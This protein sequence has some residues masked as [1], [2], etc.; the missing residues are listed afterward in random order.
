MST[1][2]RAVELGGGREF[3]H[4]LGSSPGHM[5]ESRS[6]RPVMP[7]ANQ[8]F[9]RVYRGPPGTFSFFGFLAPINNKLC[10]LSIPKRE[11]PT[12]DIVPTLAL[13]IGLVMDGTVSLFQKQ[14][15][16]KA[17][18]RQRIWAS[19]PP[20]AILNPPRRRPARAVWSRGGTASHPRPAPAAPR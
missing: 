1:T 12:A 2:L 7:S 9:S 8:T 4:G 3:W 5:P 20:N 13:S 17:A 10:T 11:G 16:D 15:F 6:P 18:G 19:A 14:M